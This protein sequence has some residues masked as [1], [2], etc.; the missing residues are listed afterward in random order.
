MFIGS[1]LLYPNMQKKGCIEAISLVSEK[2]HSLGIDI[3]MSEEHIESFNLN[4]IK[5]DRYLPEQEAF[6]ACDI[7]IVLGGDGTMLSA[8]HTACLINTPLLGINLGTL[9]YMSELEIAEIDLLDKLKEEFNCAHRMMIDI[10]VERESIQIA[11]F[12]ALNE[13]LIS[14]GAVAS[15]L[16]LNLICDGS[17]VNHYRADG[18][19]VSTPTGSSAYSMSAGGPIIDTKLDAICVC[20]VCSHSLSGSRALI[21]SP[22]SEI[23][24]KPLSEKG[25][26]IILT[27]DGRYS[28]PLKDGDSVIIT[29]SAKIT[30]FVKLKKDAFYDALNRKLG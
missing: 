8:A 11:C 13:V 30:R 29:K 9:G 1:V 22:K 17:Q 20:P 3:I 21:F 6:V 5:I 27:A 2:L 26:D 4:N 12:T 19:I 28:F 16:G 24:I 23:V 7:A 15:M 25:G 18:L 10:S 14:R